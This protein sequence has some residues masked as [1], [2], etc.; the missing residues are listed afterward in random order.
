MFFGVATDPGIG[1]DWLSSASN[2]SR[3]RHWAAGRVRRH[4]NSELPHVERELPSGTGKVRLVVVADKS[5]AGDEL[6]SLLRQE[7]CRIVALLVPVEV[8]LW[9]RAVVGPG[10]VVGT[11]PAELANIEF[12]MVVCFGDVSLARRLVREIQREVPLARLH[13]VVQTPRQPAPVA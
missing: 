8:M 5:V 4:R 9:T 1:V 12:D 2:H 13:D 7:E 11:H 10:P 6:A 3:N